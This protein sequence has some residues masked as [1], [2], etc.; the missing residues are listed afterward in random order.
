MVDGCVAV[1]GWSTDVSSN[2]GQ[3]SLCGRQCTVIC[4]G[5]LGGGAAIVVAVAGTREA[6]QA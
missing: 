5:C 4:R 3:Y 2:S 1:E 6:S